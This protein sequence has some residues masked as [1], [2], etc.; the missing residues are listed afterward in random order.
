MSITIPK[1]R[2]LIALLILIFSAVLIA[3]TAYAQSCAPLVNTPITVNGVV[4]NLGAFQPT[5]CGGDPGWRGAIGREFTVFGMA[6]G[7]QKGWM[8]IAGESGGAQ[9][10]KLDFGIHVEGNAELN[11]DDKALVYFDANNNSTFDV[12]DFAIFFEVGPLATVSGVEE[13]SKDPLTVTIY[14]FQNGSW[15]AQ[16]P[17]AGAIN[18]KVAYDFSNQLPSDM[19]NEIWELEVSL[20]VATLKANGFNLNAPVQGNAFRMGAKLFVN[21]PGAGGTTVW[22][23]PANASSEPNAAANTPNLD[24]T[25]TAANLEQ[26]SFGNCGDV[27]IESMSSEA[28]NT[29]GSYDT[30]HFRVLN[31]G[32]FVNGLVP[33]NKQTKFHAKLRFQTTPMG[34]PQAIGAPNSGTTTYNIMPWGSSGAL[35]T[36]PMRVATDSFTQINTILPIDFNWPLTKADYDQAAGQF[37]SA[38]SSHACMSLRLSGYVVN[39]NEPGDFEQHNLTY[40]KTSTVKDAF[41]LTAEK[42][43]DDRYYKQCAGDQDIVIRTRW[44]YVPPKMQCPPNATPAALQKCEAQYRWI[45]TFPTA[46]ALGIKN[47]G[48]GYYRVKLHQ[49]QSI[50]VPVTIVGGLMPNKSEKLKVSARA[51]GALVTPAS[52]EPAVDFPVEPGRV[53]TVVANGAINLGGIFKGRDNGPDGFS[54]RQFTAVGTEGRFLLR[55]GFY[56]PS[57]YLGALIGSFD[58]F[59]TSFVVGS[60]SSLI[61]PENATK[62]SLAINDFV[63]QYNDNTG[64]GFE[65]NI[66]TAD[67]ISLPTR[68]GLIGDPNFGLPGVVPAAANLPQLAIDVYRRMPT[69]KPKI[70]SLRPTGNAIFAVFES[71][72]GRERANH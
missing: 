63:G 72:A 34:A 60:N 18:A 7:S 54:N 52:G 15:T 56:N 37:N 44:L 40:I 62:L 9:L 27:I 33:D 66:L 45:Y 14:K 2:S 46:G 57:L 30:N 59:K 67:R 19:E 70:F 25:V 16:A 61:V 58:G 26:I 10:S 41:M 43:K 39:V 51:G 13:C 22:R 71:H 20:D 12:G 55:P 53:I 5:I 23:W 8:F 17:P 38:A 50:R 24:P 3:H 1:M 48:N 42:C 36:I 69:G 6:P 64:Q 31:A 68:V 49:G 65:V 4:A 11:Q 32:D 28:P 21:D 29:T 47:L 35:K